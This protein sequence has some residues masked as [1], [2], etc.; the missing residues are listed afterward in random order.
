[1]TDTQREAIEPRWI[2]V[3]MWHKLTG[4]SRTE[5]YRMI[6]AGELRA[7]R[8][9]RSLYIDARELEDFFARAAKAA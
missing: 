8:S 2:R 9:G 5:T 4:M 3:P 7:V 1:M 6:R